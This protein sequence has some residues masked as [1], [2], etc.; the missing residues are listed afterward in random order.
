MFPKK[1]VITRGQLGL[2]EIIHQYIRYD[3]IHEAINVLN[4]MNW[5]TMGHQCYICLSAIVNHLLKQ[6]LTPDREGKRLIALLMCFSGICS[7]YKDYDVIFIDCIKK[8]IGRIFSHLNIALPN[9]MSYLEI[10]ISVKSGLMCWLN[11]S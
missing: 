9:Q 5:N 11:V 4:T 1:G 2:V 6:K 3:E 7:S 10:I 8:T